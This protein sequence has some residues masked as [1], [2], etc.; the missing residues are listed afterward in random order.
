MPGQPIRFGPG[1][2]RGVARGPMAVSEIVEVDEIGERALIVHDPDRG[3]LGLAFSLA[4][5]AED[6]PGPTPIGI[7]RSVRRPVDGR[8]GAALPDD[9]ISDDQLA[10]LLDS[11]EMDRGVAATTTTGVRVVNPTRR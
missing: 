3:D 6:R 10:E 9:P 11:G 7:F 2:E 1:G 4:R 5:L 8:A